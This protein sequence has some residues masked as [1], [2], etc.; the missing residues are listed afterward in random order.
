M[1]LG[2]ANGLWRPNGRGR[3]MIKPHQDMETYLGRYSGLI[4]YLKEMDE[5][6]YG[7]L[8]AVS[9]G[10]SVH[11]RYSLMEVCSLGLLLGF[12]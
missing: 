8:C 10:S 12:Q 3:L 2:D 9:I 11:A 6:A 7:K 1:L 5:T 4:L